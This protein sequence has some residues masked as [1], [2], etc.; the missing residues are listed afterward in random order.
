MFSLVPC[1]FPC[2]FI[3]NIDFWCR[4]RHILV[5]EQQ[6]L[7]LQSPPESRNCRALC[8]LCRRKD[9]A[10]SSVLCADR[11]L[12]PTNRQRFI[13]VQ[14]TQRNFAPFTAKGSLNFNRNANRMKEGNFR[15]GMAKKTFAA[16]MLMSL[17]ILLI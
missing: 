11:Q 8:E 9:F 3:P 4:R 16:R 10:R 15:H 6:R 14:R 5:F 17:I 1:N 7:R 13:S 2:P 12:S